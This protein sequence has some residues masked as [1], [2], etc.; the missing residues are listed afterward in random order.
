M[1]YFLSEEDRQLLQALLA[2]TDPAYDLHGVD[3]DG[4]Y[5][6]PECYVAKP[7][8][9][10]GIPALT[11]GTEGGY[12]EPGVA[13]CDIFKIITDVGTAGPELQPVDDL[14]KSVYNISLQ[15]VSQRWIIVI[16][17]K[18]GKWV[19]RPERQIPWIEFVVDEAGTGTGE[20]GFTTSDLEIT[21]K[22][23]TYHS[24][25]E[26]DGGI[27]TVY[28]VAAHANYIFE[29]DEDD[30]GIALQDTNDSKYYI[31]QMECP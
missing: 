11:P 4:G 18:Y 13:T 28:N 6:A 12:D 29:G 16:R 3:W 22:D 30:R 19:V 9:E 24:G 31:I 1:P 27:D 2:K 14:D 7:A 20:G 10:T 17:T 23:V 21:V 26:P 25:V 5:Q 8:Y 15:A